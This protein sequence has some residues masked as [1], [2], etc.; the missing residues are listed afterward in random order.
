[1]FNVIIL[2]TG[3]RSNYAN[4]NNSHLTH[5][6]LDKLAAILADYIFNCIFLNENDRIPIHI[7][8]KYVPRSPVDN[9]PALIQV[10]A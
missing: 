8:L 3:L 2:H 10:M 1:M 9:K 5:L 4:T 6:P 7:L